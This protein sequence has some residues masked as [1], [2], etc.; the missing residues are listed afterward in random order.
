VF[1]A[2]LPIADDTSA[3][4]IE[5]FTDDPGFATSGLTV[6]NGNTIDF[7]VLGPLRYHDGS[8]FDDL[9]TGANLQIADNGTN[10]GVIAIDGSTTGPVSGSGV[11]AEI[12]P[13]GSIDAHIDL[14]LD[15]QTLGPD[16][17]GAYGLLMELTTDASGIA[18][19]ESFYIVFNFGLAEG[20]GNAFEG[21]VEDFAAAV[22]EPASAG[23]LL[24][25]LG[26]LGRR[27]RRA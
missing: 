2:D 25:G 20:E 15:P 12:G 1:E 11:I 7:N 13:S 6:A 8:G 17:Y 9:P 27:R 22:P 5:Q 23:L 10:A 4:L 24:A 18:N 21:A 14:F 16:A 19:S 26:L 3:D